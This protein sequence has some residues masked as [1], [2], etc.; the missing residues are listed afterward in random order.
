MAKVYVSGYTELAADRNGNKMSAPKH[1][2]VF[3]SVIDTTSGVVNTSNLPDTVTI[4]RIH[5][6]G[7]VNVSV[8]PSATAATSTAEHSCRMAAGQTEYFGVNAGAGY[9]VSAITNT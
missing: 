4:V 7:I 6:D 3:E 1:P 9:R 5:T 2:P 8:K